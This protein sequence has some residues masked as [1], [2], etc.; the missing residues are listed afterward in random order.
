MSLVGPQRIATVGLTPGRVLAVAWR[1]HVSSVVGRRGGGR[2]VLLMA[3]VMSLSSADGGAIGALAGP[4]ERSFHFGNTRLGLL[5]TVSSLVGAAGCMPMGVLVDRVNR[6]RL[7][8]AAVVL[9]SLAMAGMALADSYPALLA[10]R[11]A[12]GLV[13]SA[14]GPVVASLTGDL[15][16][17]ERRAGTY[18]LILTGDIVG[19]GVGLLASGAVNSLV[20]W[21]AAFAVLATG[22][23]VLAVVV[24][25]LLSEP[26]R[27]DARGRPGSPGATAAGTGAGGPDGPADASTEADPRLVLRGDPSSMSAWQAARY[28]LSIPSNQVL[29]L[30]SALGY[31]FLSGLRT[32]AVVF[33]QSRYRLGPALTGLLIV[34][35]GVGTVAGTVGGGRLAD[36]FSR[37]GRP[38]ARM[39][40]AGLGLAGAAL[41]FLPGLFTA[42]VAVGLPLYVGAAAL[43]AAPNA[44]IDAAR[45]DIVPA[46]LWGRA[47]AVR[48][49]TRTLLEGAAPLLFGF[50][51][52]QFSAQFSGSA[53]NA[54]AGTSSPH[55]VLTAASTH[56]LALTFLVM[57]VPLA[58]SGLLLVHRRRRY[59]IDLATALVSD[60]VAFSPQTSDG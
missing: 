21:R 8:V 17:A 36:R 42:S 19:S 9:W 24:H 6:Q 33:A 58:A 47:E 41:L 5:V 25:L 59:R 55:Q 15:F 57:L 30:S 7:L 2:A 12:L 14:A 54:A 10:T 26:P 39:S 45:L 38:E 23:M 43:L 11:V 35:I 32:F 37:R 48:T 31:F 49:V 44:P 3:A 4:L 53:R 13:T 20:D 60:Q 40:V 46:R 52:S 28:V 51:S 22:S 16:P 56:G 27:G 1:R 29:I 18:G 50:V 34:V